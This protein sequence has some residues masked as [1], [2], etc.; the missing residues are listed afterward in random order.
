M[1]RADMESASPRRHTLQAAVFEPEELSA[2]CG[3]GGTQLVM[4]VD[5]TR[6]KGEMVGRGKVIS[7]VSKWSLARC[8]GR[9]GK[10]LSTRLPAQPGR[11]IKGRMVAQRGVADAR[12]LVGQGAG[13]LV[14]VASALDIQRPAADAADI[15]ARSIGHFGRPQ[16]TAR[17]VREQHAQVAVTLLGD[18]TQV[19]FD[20]GAGPLTSMR[21]RRIVAGC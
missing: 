10:A 1:S 15:F 11:F 2:C 20:I 16:H 3:V 9:D 7:L 8:S 21:P 19:P 6:R 17:T 5:Q 18:A 4:M 14:V 12:E 13:G